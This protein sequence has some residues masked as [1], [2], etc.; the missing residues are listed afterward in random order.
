[1]LLYRNELSILL[2]S[3][4]FH[5]HGLFLLLHLSFVNLINFSDRNILDLYKKN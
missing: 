5:F 2:V 1:M 3:S 4:I